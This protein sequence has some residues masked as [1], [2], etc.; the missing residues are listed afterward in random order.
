MH[1][2]SLPFSS[3]DYRFSTQVGV[4]NVVVVDVTEDVYDFQIASAELRYYDSA[5]PVYN[6]VI[7]RK[8]ITIFSLSSLLCSARCQ[9]PKSRSRGSRSDG[10]S[11]HRVIWLRQQGPL[12]RYKSFGRQQLK[13]CPVQRLPVKLN[14]V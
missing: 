5:I 1:R 6:A 7:Q 12:R 11:V 2:R 14:P 4:S 13:R 8:S 10:P 3:Q 9:T